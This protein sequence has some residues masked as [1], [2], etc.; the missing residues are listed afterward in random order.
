MFIKS[1]EQNPRRTPRRTK[2]ASCCRSAE[3]VKPH[4]ALQAC[5]TVSKALEKS[6]AMKTTYGLVD[7]SCVTVR[8]M[9]IRAAA[10]KPDGRK[11]N[12]SV[13][14]RVVISLEEKVEEVLH[15]SSLKCSSE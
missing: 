2:P 1:R 4:Q 9:Y 12:W 15:N 5:R 14:M 3:V 7:R 13:K 10:V 6:K 8:K 11:A